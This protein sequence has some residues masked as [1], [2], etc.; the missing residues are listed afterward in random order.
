MVTFAAPKYRPILAATG[1]T[2][3]LAVDAAPT[4]VRVRDGR[5]VSGTLLSTAIPSY[6]S[7]SQ[8]AT[9]TV[10]FTGA[11]TPRD[12][13]IEWD[14]GS[15]FPVS[16]LGVITTLELYPVIGDADLFLRARVLDPTSTMAISDL[17]SFS[18]YREEAW[19][20]LMNYLDGRGRRPWLILAPS[21][22]R[23]AHILLTLALIFADFDS[24]T[25]E[26]GYDV[27]RQNY[28]ESYEKELSSLIL[29]YAEDSK[30][31]K[32]GTFWLGGR[33]Q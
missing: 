27:R 22:L 32:I 11:L 15:T 19:T 21:A 17:T 31:A 33:G 10:T 23:E 14:V 9:A 29:E 2:L 18:S 25:P 1:G 12:V 30:G 4:A 8:I 13:F 3:R 20:I 7:V 28:H 5:G 24:R 26:A 6:D 16:F